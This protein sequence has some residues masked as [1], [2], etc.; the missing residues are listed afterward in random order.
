MNKFSESSSPESGGG[1]VSNAP[2]CQK[3]EHVK[4]LGK[5]GRLTRGAVGVMTSVQTLGFVGKLL[6]PATAF[7][8]GAITVVGFL[9]EVSEAQCNWGHNHTVTRTTNILWK[10]VVMALFI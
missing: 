4:L 2:M 7:G 6:S 5:G 9:A 1:T 3:A 8:V 10:N